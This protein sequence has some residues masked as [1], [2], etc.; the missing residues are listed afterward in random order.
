ML[1]SQW[2][3]SLSCVS[4]AVR[5]ISTFRVINSRAHHLSNN[6]QAAQHL[7]RIDPLIIPGYE[8]LGYLAAGNKILGKSFFRKSFFSIVKQG[9]RIVSAIVMFHTF[10]CCCAYSF[11]IRK[12]CGPILARLINLVSG[13]ETVNLATL[14]SEGGVEGVSLP[15]QT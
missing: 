15:M 11:V 14:R 13:S 1:A 4:P 9:K 5:S 3:Y 7:E 8:E 2:P 12:E 10:T 6:N